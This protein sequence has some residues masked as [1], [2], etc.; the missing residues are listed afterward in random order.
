MTICP[1]YQTAYKTDV[2][3]RYNVTASDI[4]KF[5]FQRLKNLTSSEFFRMVTFDLNEVLKDMHI[6][7]AYR[8]K[9]SRV[10]SF[11]LAE[12]WQ[13]GDHP[14]EFFDDDIMHL[15]YRYQMPKTFIP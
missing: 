13:N 14:T 11:Y 3:A 12:K 1:D 7:G 8:I 6:E 2:L 10:T 5:R 4:R 9:G 15:N